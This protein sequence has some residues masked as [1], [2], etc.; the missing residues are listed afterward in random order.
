M[1]KKSQNTKEPRRTYTDQLA[2]DTGCKAI[3]LPNA[4]NKRKIGERVSCG[5]EQARSSK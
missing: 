1:K 5:V 2:D 3:E 4:M